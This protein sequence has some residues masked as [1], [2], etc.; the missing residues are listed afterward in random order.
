MI[1]FTDFFCNL[2]GLKIENQISWHLLST[3]NR[4]VHKQCASLFIQQGY[5]Q[6]ELFEYVDNVS[7]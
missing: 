2:C 5:V 3:G 7:I 1:P 4:M 6:M